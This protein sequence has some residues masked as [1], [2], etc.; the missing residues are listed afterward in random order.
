MKQEVE[1][2]KVEKDLRTERITFRLVPA[3][4]TLVESEAKRREITVTEL[5]EEA[6]VK[7]LSPSA[8]RNRV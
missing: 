6:L 4:K 7:H 3:W 1:K 8:G 5:L 2:Q